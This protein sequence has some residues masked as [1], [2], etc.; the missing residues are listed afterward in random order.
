MISED[1]F[2][3]LISEF[4]TKH[5]EDTFN[6]AKFN[7]QLFQYALNHVCDEERKEREKEEEMRLAALPPRKSYFE[8]VKSSSL[9]FYIS[10]VVAIFAVGMIGMTYYTHSFKTPNFNVIK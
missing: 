10:V 2:I 5:A 3:K 8:M 7:F 9:S 6:S 4:S 1:L